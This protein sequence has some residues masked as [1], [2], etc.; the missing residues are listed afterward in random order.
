[1]YSKLSTPENLSVESDTIGWVD[2]KVIAATKTRWNKQV[3]YFKQGV[4]FEIEKAVP[5]EDSEIEDALYDAVRQRCHC[6]HD[7]CGHIFS[8]LHNLRKLPDNRWLGVISGG[9]NV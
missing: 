9:R 8:H 1:M 3:D 4:L 2:A 6:E 5:C 7:C